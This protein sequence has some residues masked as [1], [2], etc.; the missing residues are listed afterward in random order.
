MTG[1]DPAVAAWVEDVTGGTIES[2]TPMGGGGRPGWGIDV[3][4]DGTGHAL[5]LQKG[6]GEN[7]GSFLPIGRETEVVKALE[8]LG[9]PVPRLWA[10]DVER[11]WA[12]VGRA[13]GTT[14]FQPPR[15][16]AEAE[17]VARDFMVHL[18]AWHRAGAAG[19]DLPSFQPVKSVRAHQLDQLAGI[20]TVFEE[21]DARAPIDALARLELELLESELPAHDGAP[22]LVQGDTGPGNFMYAGRRVTAIVD[23]ELAHLGDPMDDLAWLSWRATQ[24]SFPDFPARLREYERHSGIEVDDDRVRYYRVN[25]VARLGPRFGLPPMTGS[26]GPISGIQ[27]GNPRSADGSVFIMGMLHRRMVVTALAELAGLP[28][29]PRQVDEEAEPS[30]QNVMYDGLLDNLSAV[31]PQ[32]EDR[33]ASTVVKGVA[34]HL[35]YLK[36]LDR[37]GRRFEAQELDDIRATTGTTFDDLATA[38]PALAEAARE[39][40][41][42]AEDYLRYHFRRMTRDDWLMRTASGAMFDRAWPELR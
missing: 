36:E 6:R 29:P 3:R 38:R 40:R 26:G 8:P 24:H 31:V 33:A 34:R 16:P 2:A 15:D 10:V 42:P 41:V 23:W 35:K 17:A 39:G 13:E 37:N 12:L 4:V 18:A 11:G 21:E 30:P 25:A 19:L 32:I 1:L 14:W 27:A 20:R 9:L 7:V 28:L 22:V 5:Y